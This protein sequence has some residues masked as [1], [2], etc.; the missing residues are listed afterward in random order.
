MTQYQKRV[1]SCGLTFLW[2]ALIFYMSSQPAAESRELSRGVTVWIAEIIERLAPKAD[3]DFRSLHGALRKQ[4][5]FWAYLVLG[6]LVLN[7]LRQSG[8]KGRRAVVLAMTVSVVYAIT[9]EIH[10]LFVPGRSGEVFDVVIDTAGAAT[11]MAVYG[12]LGWISR[13]RQS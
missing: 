2:M 11:G 1:L 3:I 6:P 4:A 9:D 13:K 8:V 10:Q 7:A 5:H 12:L